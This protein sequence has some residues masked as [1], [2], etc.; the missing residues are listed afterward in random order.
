VRAV[1]RDVSYLFHTEGGVKTKLAR[2]GIITAL[3]LAGTRLHQPVT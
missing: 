3:N 1:T 2:K